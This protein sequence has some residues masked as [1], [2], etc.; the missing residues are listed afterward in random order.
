[1]RLASILAFCVLE[2]EET[3]TAYDCVSRIAVAPGEEGRGSR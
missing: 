1:M 3:E 2:T